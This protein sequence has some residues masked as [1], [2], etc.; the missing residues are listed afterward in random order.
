MWRAGAPARL[1]LL[2]AISLYRVTLSGW[3][4]GQCRFSPTCSHYAADA[5]RTHGAARGSLLAARRVLRC[6]PFGRGGLD[7]VPL[8]RSYD[9][10]IQT[11]SVS[12]R[13]AG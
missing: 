7:P 8:K 9:H 13:H 5:I 3:L 4:G 2:G 12:E 11:V 1:L 6:N 10:A